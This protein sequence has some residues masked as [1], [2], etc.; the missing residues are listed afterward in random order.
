MTAT[1]L[2]CAEDA[3]TKRKSMRKERR[4][5]QIMEAGGGWGGL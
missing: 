2:R 4:S 1:A 5:N 3:H